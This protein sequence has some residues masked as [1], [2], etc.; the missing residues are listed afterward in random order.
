MRRLL[1]AV[2]AASPAAAF[3]GT[4]PTAE[5]QV[6]DWPAPS[7][8][9]AE[10]MLKEYEKPTRFNQDMLIWSD[11]GAWKRTVVYRAPEN[12]SL[13]QTINYVVP[14]EKISALERF[15]K[16]LRFDFAAGELSAR[17][18]DER[19]NYLILNLA[20]EIVDD[21]RGVEDARDFERK[22]EALLK[23]GKTSPYLDGFRFSMDDDDL[24]L[25]DRSDPSAR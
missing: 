21:K 7:R 24:V 20:E 16:R 4:A 5:L 6:R 14:D 10:A 23:S 9:A 19:L 13:E 12:G 18:D 8:A 25:P 1:F 3:A 15:D 17:S 2:L 22:T 11:D